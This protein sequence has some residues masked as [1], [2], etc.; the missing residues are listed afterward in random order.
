MKTLIIGI[1]MLICIVLAATNPY[2]GPTDDAGDSY[3]GDCGD[4]D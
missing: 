2:D 4:C 1:F 3:T